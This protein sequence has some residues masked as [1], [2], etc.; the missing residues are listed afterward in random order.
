[1][2]DIKIR[3]TRHAQKKNE[4]RGI[5]PDLVKKTVLSYQEKILDIH[6]PEL[7]HYIRCVENRFLRVIGRWESQDTFLVVTSFFDRRLKGR[8]DRHDKNQL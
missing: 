3:L 1:M 8:E 5:T 4:D 7:V 6:D 2:K